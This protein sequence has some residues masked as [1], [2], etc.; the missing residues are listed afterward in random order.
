MRKASARNGMGRQLH[1]RSHQWYIHAIDIVFAVPSL[2]ALFPTKYGSIQR[3][4]AGRTGECGT[5]SVATIADHVDQHTVSRRAVDQATGSIIIVKQ[6]KAVNNQH[7]QQLQA[8]AN[9]STDRCKG[10]VFFFFFVVV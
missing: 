7:Q 2:P 6:T 5:T 4:I 8:R 1:C 10:L 9:N 3:Q